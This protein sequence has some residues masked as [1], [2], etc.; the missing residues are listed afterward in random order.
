MDRPRSRPI[1]GAR[2]VALCSGSPEI[3][4]RCRYGPPF[5]PRRV[6][7]HWLQLSAKFILVKLAATAPEIGNAW[8]LATMEQIAAQFGV[9][10][11]TISRDLK[12]IVAPRNNVKADRGQIPNS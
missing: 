3:G 5:L 1:E 8:S 11:A 12:D 9:D 10:K 6:L 2:V 7:Y 4:N